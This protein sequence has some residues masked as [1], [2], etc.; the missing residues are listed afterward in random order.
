VKLQIRTISGV[1]RCVHD[2]HTQRNP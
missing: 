1:L 2:E